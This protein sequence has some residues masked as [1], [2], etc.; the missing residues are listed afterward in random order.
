MK[1]TKIPR[2]EVINFSLIMLIFMTGTIAMLL[3]RIENIWIWIGYIS[4][5]SWLEVR[6]AK[7]IH[8]SWWVW[9]LI[10]L[11]ICGLDLIIIGL[12]NN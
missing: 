5:W 7:N 9:G 11:G 2:K 3:Y 6:V 8:L 4:L 10:I 12:I 1:E